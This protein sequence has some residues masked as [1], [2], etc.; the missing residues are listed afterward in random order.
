MKGKRTA[1][2]R[3]QWPNQALSLLLDID[4]TSSFCVFSFIHHCLFVCSCLHFCP[5]NQWLPSLS[6]LK[7]LFI[8]PSLRL[9]PLYILSFVLSL[10]A[11][12]TYF[13][14]SGVHTSPSGFLYAHA[15]ECVCACFFFAPGHPMGGFTRL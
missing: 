1:L 4:C 12:H 7:S 15:I 9:S 8:S 2:F 14:P 3:P 13:Q 11:P 6:S 5:C 10:H